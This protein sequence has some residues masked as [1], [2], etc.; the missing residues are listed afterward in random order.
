V[1]EEV[2]KLKSEAEKHSQTLQ[3]KDREIF[4][5]KD[6]Y[7][8]FSEANFL[9]CLFCREDFRS[10]DYVLQR[11]LLCLDRLITISLMFDVEPKGLYTQNN[12]PDSLPY[13]LMIRH[14][15]DILDKLGHI[16]FKMYGG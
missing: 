1:R 9:V 12:E 8:N 7:L 13:E 11:L 14:Y 2:T 5:L 15:G 3:R 16:M 6:T 4:L 10:G